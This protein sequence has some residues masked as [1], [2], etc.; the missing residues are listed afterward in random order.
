MGKYNSNPI[1]QIYW[2][3]RLKKIY[4]HTVTASAAE[5]QTIFMFGKNGLSF[6]AKQCGKKFSL[7]KH[8]KDLEKFKLNRLNVD[9]ILALKPTKCNQFDDECEEDEN[10]LHVTKD[11]GKTW[12]KIL[13]NVYSV[14]I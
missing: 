10:Q 11:Q 1:R 12:E 8:D 2:R 4:I 14:I 3:N 9:L 13:D 7:I 5:P 6:V